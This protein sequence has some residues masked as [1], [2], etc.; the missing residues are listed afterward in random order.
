M[1]TIGVRGRHWLRKARE[2]CSRYLPA[3]VVGTAFSVIGAYAAFHLWGDRAVAAL[4]GT[5]A[6]NAG[7]YGVMAV[8]EWR[9]QAS[10][11]PGRRRRA[12]RTAMALSTELGPAEAIDSLAVRPLMLF[13][14][15]FLTG[16]I[17][18]GSALGKIMADVVFYVVVIACYEAGQRRAAARRRL[19]GVTTVMPPVPRYVAVLAGGPPRTE[20]AVLAGA[21]SR[22]ERGSGT[23]PG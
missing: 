11:A 4:A 19:A 13:L 14:G 17:A 22:T 1:A 15:P 2:W 7:F 21:R 20:R 9:R 10:G 16:G 8:L 18:T 6:E 5:L 23:G 3:E 12:G